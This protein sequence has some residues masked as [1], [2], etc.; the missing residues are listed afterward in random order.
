MK[1]VGYREIRK[2]LLVLSVQIPYR[3][4]FN[5]L[6]E[7]LHSSHSRCNNVSDFQCLNVCPGSHPLAIILA[8]KTKFIVGNIVTGRLF[9]RWYKYLA[10][11]CLV[12]IY[13]FVHLYKP[14]KRPTTPHYQPKQ[15]PN[16][17]SHTITNYKNHKRS[18]CN[19]ISPGSA[20]SALGVWATN[21]ER[22]RSNCKR[23]NFAPLQ[24]Y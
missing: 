17:T 13:S 20:A 6:S 2:T 5:L 9:R 15:I 3:E 21:A 11:N 4:A 12:P 1:N 16:T 18:S 7:L 22:Q 19:L 14:R 24:E 10:S 23:Y 8:T